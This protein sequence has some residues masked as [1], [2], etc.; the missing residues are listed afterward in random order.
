MATASATNPQVR[1]GPAG[2]N[3]LPQGAAKQLNAA[4][5][6]IPNE[7]PL[8]TAGQRKIEPQGKVTDFDSVLFRGTDHPDEP[9]TH[10]APFGPGADFLAGGPE[11]DNAFLRRAAYETALA[12]GADNR[13][14]AYATRVARG[15]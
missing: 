12:P 9:I 4:A 2:P 6:G 10:G 15:E 7:A 13:A 14:R 8:L 3:Q 11:G 1:K 5:Q